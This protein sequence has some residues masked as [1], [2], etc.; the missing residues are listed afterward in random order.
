MGEVFTP[1]IRQYFAVHNISDPLAALERVKDNIDLLTDQAIAE[2]TGWS[3]EEVG[4]V[5]TPGIRKHLA[6]HNIS[7][8]LK[9]ATDYIAGN[10]SFGGRYYEG[11]K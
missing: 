2:K 3:L 7:D 11:T 5:F 4:E 9:G 10:I 1:G 6:V 8:P